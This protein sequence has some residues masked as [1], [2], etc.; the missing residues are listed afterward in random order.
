MLFPNNIMYILGFADD[1]RQFDTASYHY[2]GKFV[3]FS[4]HFSFTFIF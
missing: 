2:E 4:G 1:M 3:V